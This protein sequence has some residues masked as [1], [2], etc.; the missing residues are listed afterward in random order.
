MQEQTFLTVA[1]S[2]AMPPPV[3]RRARKDLWHS[4]SPNALLEKKK[5]T[6]HHNAK[7]FLKTS[8]KSSRGQ[9]FY[10]IDNSVFS[11]HFLH[12]MKLFRPFRNRNV[13]QKKRILAHAKE[14]KSLRRP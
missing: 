8:L 6:Q 1:R 4:Q 7:K 3:G 13:D 14:F 12:L 5:P 10:G 9:D 2:S 11:F